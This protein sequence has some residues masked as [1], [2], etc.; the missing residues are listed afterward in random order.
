MNN[1]IR[2][3]TEKVPYVL[4]AVVLNVLC[5]FLFA[6]MIQVN[7]VDIS[8]APILC[9]VSV[10]VSIFLGTYF[11]AV[12]F[13]SAVC[14]Y[15]LAIGYVL[16]TLLLSIINSNSAIFDAGI[17]KLIISLICGIILGNFLGKRSYYKMRNFGK[18]S[19]FRRK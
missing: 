16:V 17:V 14:G 13:G 4:I 3:A 12:K 10:I 18:K 2:S 11:S 6:K 5:M 1:M 7:I 8:S 9:I 15:I 19:R